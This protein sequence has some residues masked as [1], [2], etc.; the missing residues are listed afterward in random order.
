MSNQN[1][2]L[3]PAPD[4][5]AAAQWAKDYTQKP[6][7]KDGNENSIN[8]FWISIVLLLFALAAWWWWCNYRPSNP[9]LTE[10]PTKSSP[11]Q[12]LKN[13]AQKSTTKLQVRPNGTVSS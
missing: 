2:N 11:M 3:N 7:G 13:G 9:Q 12:D 5:N 4:Y 1:G 6:N 8:I 10:G